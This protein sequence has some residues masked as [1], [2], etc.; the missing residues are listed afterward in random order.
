[1]R[2]TR[3]EGYFVDGGYQE[4]KLMVSLRHQ[5]DIRVEMLNGQSDIK[6]W[7]SGNGLGWK[8]TY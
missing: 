7:S 1:M 3:R 5:L 4:L 2:K 6:T 8:Y